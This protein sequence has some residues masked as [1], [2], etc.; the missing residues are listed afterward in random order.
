MSFFYRFHWQLLWPIVRSYFRLSVQGGEQIPST[1]PILLAA[2]HC[3]YLDPP[4]I[5]LGIPRQLTFLA[6]A[7][8]FSYPIL[9]GW[10]RRIGVYP[11]ARG[12]G[13][14][15]A[16]RTALRLLRESKALLLFPEGTR[17]SNGELQ[18]LEEGV[19][20]LSLK[21]GVLIVPVYLSGTF[22]SF[23]R[24]AWF[25][26]PVRVR[27]GVGA[28]IWPGSIAP[29]RPQ[30]ERIVALNERL[31][32]ELIRLKNHQEFQNAAGTRLESLNTP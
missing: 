17:S 5:A 12:Q 23:P 21:S 32:Q 31:K 9:A 4:L 8:L 30:A 14:A 10:F 27:M 2:N 18:P 28:P 29:D 1:G 3:S 13:D 19:A 24:Q 20:W 15:R 16:V 11:V 25:P 7:E 26:R 6:K 22:R